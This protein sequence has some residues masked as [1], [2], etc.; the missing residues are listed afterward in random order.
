MIDL[1][2]RILQY[3]GGAKGYWTIPAR[4]RCAAL[5]AKETLH[6]PDYSPEV[7]ELALSVPQVWARDKLECGKID[8]VIWINGNDSKPQRQYRFPV[9]AENSIQ[10]TIDSL[11]SQQVIVQIHSVCNSPIWPV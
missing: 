2:N 9:E 3:T 5:K 7:K 4:H 10:N 8:T 1:P 6:F 11:V